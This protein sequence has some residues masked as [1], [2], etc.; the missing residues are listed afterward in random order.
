MS[1]LINLPVQKSGLASL[2]VWPHES[3]LDLQVWKSGLV[4]LQVWKS[5]FA[6]LKVWTCESAS[7]CESESLDL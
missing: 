2:K 4:N 7:L 6:S 1:G 3:A 5:G